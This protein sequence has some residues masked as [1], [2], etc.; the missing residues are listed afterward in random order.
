MR[1]RWIASLLFCVLSVTTVLTACG[2]S[3]QTSDM[4]KNS[5]QENTGDEVVVSEVAEI[6][7][8]DNLVKENFYE[9]KNTISPLVLDIVNGEGNSHDST[10]YEQALITIDINRTFADI[11]LTD[12]D[13][14]KTVDTYYKLL[15]KNISIYL[16]IIN[17][18]DIVQKFG[19]EWVEAQTLYAADPYSLS[20]EFQTI[21][22]KY[23]TEYEVAEEYKASFKQ[24]SVAI[25]KDR[26]RLLR[27]Y[28][29]IQNEDYVRYYATNSFGERILSQTNTCLDALTN[30]IDYM[31]GIVKNSYPVITKLE[32]GI[33]TALENMAGY[34]FPS[35]NQDIV[36]DVEY[37]EVIYPQQ[38]SA[39]DSILILRGYSMIDPVDV[40]VEV[41]IP[42][43]TQKY[44]QTVSLDENCKKLYIKPPVITGDVNLSQAKEAQ[45]SVNVTKV[46]DNSLIQS[47]TYPISLKSRNDFEFNWQEFY[48]CDKLNVLCLLEPESDAIADLKR[49]AVDYISQFTN[50]ALNSLSG[51]QGAGNF[52]ERL[53]TCYQVLG[54]QAAMSEMGVKYVFSP[55]SVS[56]SSQ[57]INLPSETLEKKGG[58]CIETSLVMASALQSLNMNVFLVFPP[59]HCQVAVETWKESGEYFLIETTYLPFEGQGA[60][61]NVSDH[62]ECFG[63]PT[64]PAVV[65]LLSNEQWNEYLQSCDIIDC[66]D[67][68]SLGLTALA[69]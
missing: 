25:L 24:L 20:N 27:E 29:A 30:D 2:S 57:S 52:S 67:A 60:M 12:D 11:S 33:E 53:T 44:T 34:S 69:N 61:C 17:L 46:S 49:Q 51:Y 36:I 6:D 54:I 68:R 59:G 64:Q 66:S 9:T 45:L 63:I 50:G 58:L 37:P 21:Y 26:E 48:T 38:Y 19:E 1:K 43:F 35:V 42:G 5:V 65:S 3:A 28:Q 23:N 32:S 16:D 7:A 18:V 31:K 10:E 22:D 62:P 14:K 15:E 40:L 13:F 55:Y 39:Y 47:N 41:E 56:G 4:E 8:I